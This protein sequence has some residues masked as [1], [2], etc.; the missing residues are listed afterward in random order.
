MCADLV[1]LGGGEPQEV[2]KGT[3]QEQRPS[4][5]KLAAASIASSR[6]SASGPVLFTSACSA[7]STTGWPVSTLPWMA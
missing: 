6:R 1:K 3:E 2:G 4:P 7:A 5:P